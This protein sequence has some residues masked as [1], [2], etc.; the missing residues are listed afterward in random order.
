MSDGERTLSR[1]QR[2]LAG[3]SGGRGHPRSA[4]RAAGAP[5]PSGAPPP[6]QVSTTVERR[7][8]LTVG[9]LAGYLALVL[10]A[11]LG[12]LL[13]P[14]GAWLL[15]VGL[16][17]AVAVAAGPVRFPPR[18]LRA[19][20]LLAASSVVFTVDDLI[21]APQAP[22]VRLVDVLYAPAY[23]LLIV[24]LYR[25]NRQLSGSSSYLDAAVMATGLVV[26]LIAV[27]AGPASRTD[28]DKLTLLYPLAGLVIL[29]MSVRL[30][31]PLRTG[32]S[33]LMVAAAIWLLASGILPAFVDPADG[34]VLETLRVGMLA[35]W[36]LAA[37]FPP[38]GQLATVAAFDRGPPVWLFALVVLLV[39]VAL[40]IHAVVNPDTRE[41]VLALA[42]AAAGVFV[43]TRLGEAA[44]ERTTDPVTGMIVIPVLLIN[45]RK[46]LAAGK[47]PTL[48]LVDLQKFHLVT[49]SVG[50]L[51]GDQVLRQAGQRLS[52]A[53]G[54]AEVARDRLERFAV[55]A[56]LPAADGAT[57]QLA[58][59]LTAAVARPVTVDGQ[60]VHLTCILGYATA[61]SADVDE[62]LINAEAA[63]H[64]ANI[65]GPGARIAY[66]QGL[67]EAD[68]ERARLTAGLPEAIDTGQLLL[69]YQPIVV[70]ADGVIAGFEALVRWQHP[71]LG[72]LGP[73]RFV[74]L[75]ESAGLIGDLGAWVLSQGV[76]GAAAL[77]TAAD[78]PVF[79]DINV[80]AGQFGPRLA[81]DLRSALT[82]SG[83]DP[84]LIVLELTETMLISNRQHLADELAQLKT[85]GV[86]VAIDDFGTGH[87]SLARL[88]QLPIDVIK[89]DR[90]FVDGL[91]PG[92]PAQMITGILQIATS[93]HV[94]VVA[95]GIEQT[96]ERDVLATLGCR[97]GQGYLYSRPVGLDQAQ[98]LLQAGP[99]IR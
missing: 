99:I 32:Q 50:R 96:T 60:R 12:R 52:Q 13:W 49:E 47:A 36:G 59:E 80:S 68:L 6:G 88:K 77:N 94:D 81:R 39:P 73:N 70:L 35:C 14:T 17:T 82:D 61:G 23:A 33:W 72:R 44:R 2:L 5:T 57:D 10:A 54:D 43:V 30:L 42:C 75:A 89:I 46:Q 15:L 90:M 3:V 40:L 85:T 55:L 1:L 16:A 53:A 65:A 97:L 18:D 83:V 84:P 91:T 8:L 9:L 38:P 45:A 92:G 71:E 26:L 64:A 34:F 74:H 37:L 76:A 56:D 11:G 20:L 78:R 48:F 66:D 69:E 31:R 24:A 19:H 95:E 58:G 41:A 4:G 87:S 28:P 67:R 98:A 51:G 25:L 7:N 63:L 86:R 93:L 79:V 21:S 29:T 62:L 27:L 22:P